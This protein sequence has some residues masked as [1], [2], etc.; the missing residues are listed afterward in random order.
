MKSQ[1]TALLIS[2]GILNASFLQTVLTEEQPD[3]VVAADAGLRLCKETGLCPDC[4]VGDFDSVAADILKDYDGKT[5]IVTHQPEKDATDT[6]LAIELAIEAGCDRIL[7]C[8]ATG[9]R[10]DHM[11]ANLD[12]LKCM[13]DCKVTGVVLDEQNRITLHNSSFSM[14]K[15]TC[16]GTYF[17][18]IPYSD[19][20]TGV[21]LQGMKYPLT[22]A[23]L[24]KGKQ[25]GLCVSNEIVEETAHITLREGMVL[26]IESKDR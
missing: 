26:A 4:I 13:L 15:K 6:E 3:Y 8:G 20:V 11:L 18:L 16:Y 5:R 23:T 7:L 25:S 24:K 14:S 10:I 1:K 2:G 12:T 21:T 19:V 9:G 17:S 22:D